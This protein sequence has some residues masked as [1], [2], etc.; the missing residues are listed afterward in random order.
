M[1]KLSLLSP[2]LCF[3]SHVLI[4]QPQNDPPEIDRYLTLEEVVRLARNESPASFRNDNFYLN[5]YW[6]YR[7]YQ[8]NYLPQLTLSGTLP[9]LSNQFEPVQQPD[10]DL[11]IRKVAR[12]NSSLQLSLSQNIGLTGGQVFLQSTIGR[13]DNF[14]RNTVGYNAN[15]ASIGLLQ[16]LFQFNP[17]RWDRRIEPL[18]FQEA[19]RQYSSQMEDIAVEATS[20]YFDLLVAQIA[21]DIARKNKANSDTLFQIAQGRFNLGKIAENDLLQLEL[22]LMRSNQEVTQSEL[23]V[24]VGQQALANY[25]GLTG[26][27]SIVLAEP[28]EIP[29]FDV[30]EATALAEAQTNHPDVI[31]FQRR[32]LEAERDVA[33]ARGNN[34]L[35]ADVYASYGLTQ[36][37]STVP[38]LYVDPQNQQRLRVG[39]QIPILNWGRTRS[40]IQRA[41]ANQKVVDTD[42][43]QEQQN[44][45]QAVVLA[46]ARFRITRQQLEVAIKADEIGQKRFE[47][48]K[49]RY[50]IGKIGITDLNIAQQEKDQARRAYVTAL[51][52]FWLSYYNLRRLT[53]YDFAEN[54]KI[55]YEV[56]R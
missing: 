36:Q 31:G 41:A 45:E 38:D 4:A 53:L 19:Q 46:V 21:L 27:E 48:T 34:G 51:R 28:I 14:Q 16:P 37:A 7:T 43:T 20:R 10:G 29:L 40:E 32:I 12:S 39:F 5:Q 24:R 17:L 13:V 54:Q 22:S 25:L 23:D 18:R 55:I 42:I 35:N 8:S 1:N 26:I 3:L 30:N 50:V 33:Q 49:N 6:Q 44:F 56:N 2:L 47:I 52:D 9:D 15:P 11:E